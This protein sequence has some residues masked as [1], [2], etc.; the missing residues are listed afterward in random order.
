MNQTQSCHKADLPEDVLV[1]LTGHQW[2]PNMCCA[3]PWDAIA[4]ANPLVS[5]NLSQ[6][7]KNPEDFHGSNCCG[8]CGSLIKR[9][10]VN[11]PAEHLVSFT[12]VSMLQ[13]PG[14]ERK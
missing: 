4:A 9:S 8:I 14:K 1:L 7:I 3:L 6:F 13:P 11:V 5:C 2:V 10:I 12:A